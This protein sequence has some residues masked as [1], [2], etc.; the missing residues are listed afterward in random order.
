MQ[1][2]S[3]PEHM[4]VKVF[5]SISD[6]INIETVPP[7]LPC[8][9][10]QPWSFVEFY[11]PSHLGYPGNGKPASHF[12]VISSLS[13]ELASVQY[14]CTGLQFRCSLRKNMAMNPTSQF[15]RPSP[16]WRVPQSHLPQWKKKSLSSPSW[17]M[18]VAALVES[19]L[20]TSVDAARLHITAVR[21][22]KGLPGRHIKYP[23]LALTGKHQQCRNVVS[24]HWP[25]NF[26]PGS[27]DDILDRMSIGHP[28]LVQLQPSQQR[29]L[30]Q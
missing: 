25:R 5:C 7:L 23:A 30:F 26:T 2:V 10:A 9:L 20:H 3:L 18:P 15:T 28:P 6:F 11:R 27:L 17:S 13:V 24:H 1:V 29:G 22:V 12:C 19:L 4:Y 16:V 21:P 8:R 14:T